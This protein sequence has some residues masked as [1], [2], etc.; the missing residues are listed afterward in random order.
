MGVEARVAAAVEA[1]VET[2]NNDGKRSKRKEKETNVKKRGVTE[3][4]KKRTRIKKTKRKK[5]KTMKTINLI[6]KDFAIN[7]RNDI[8]QKILYFFVSL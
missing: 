1:I 2:E 3:K 7:A 6:K 5:T 8:F 4:K